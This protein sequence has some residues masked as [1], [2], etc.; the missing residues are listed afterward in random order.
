MK[1]NDIIRTAMREQG[2]TQQDLGTKL[3]IKQNAVSN[4][5]TRPNITLA[6][7]ITIMDILGYD[8]II[9]SRDTDHSEAVT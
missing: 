9:K 7:F 6:K 8:I 4:T 3:G 1:F 5:I 2:I